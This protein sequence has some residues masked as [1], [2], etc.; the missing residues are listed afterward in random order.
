MSDFT[1][2]RVN[3]ATDTL[4]STAHTTFVEIDLRL[5][6]VSGVVE[7]TRKRFRDVKKSVDSNGG[8]KKVT[9]LLTELEEAVLIDV[10]KQLPVEV[11]EKMNNMLKTVV[12]REA[13]SMGYFVATD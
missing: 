3:V 8:E 1:L 2:T 10:S 4:L 7:A 9:E 6:A 5:V 13:K 11:P 12:T